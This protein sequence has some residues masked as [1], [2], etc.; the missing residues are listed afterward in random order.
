MLVYRVAHATKKGEHQFPLGPYQG[1]DRSSEL[2][3]INWAHSGD[4]DHPTPSSDGIRGMESTDFCALPSMGWLK[5]WFS[6]WFG[7]L[8][9][10]DYRIWV[11]DVPSDAVKLG[12]RQLVFD[13][14]RAKLIRTEPCVG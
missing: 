14:R 8:S 12:Y 9:K 10:D 5:K 2:D 1:Y 6:G 7:I 13:Y 11:Y 4:D 3:E